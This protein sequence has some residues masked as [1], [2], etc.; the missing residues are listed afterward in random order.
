MD[1]SDDSNAVWAAGTSD[2]LLG[3]PRPRLG[4]LYELPHPDC[5]PFRAMMAHPPVVQRLSWMLGHGY[6]ETQEPIANLWP[7]GT[8]GCVAVA[9]VRLHDCSY[10]NL[11]PTTPHSRTFENVLRSCSIVLTLRRC[12]GP[13]RF[14]LHADEAD[15]GYTFATSGD[16]RT[17]CDQVNVQV[18]THEPETFTRELNSAIASA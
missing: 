9:R 6:H 4:G 14:S 12:W 18:G 7:P 5:D 13:A 3:K 2:R 11:L 8:G 16:G 15:K 10:N 17:L 1:I